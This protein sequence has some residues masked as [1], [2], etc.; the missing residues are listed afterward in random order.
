MRFGLTL[1]V[2][3]F[4]ILCYITLHHI[5]LHAPAGQ[6]VDDEGGCETTEGNDAP[7]QQDGR[8][9]WVFLWGLR[10]ETHNDNLCYSKFKDL[11]N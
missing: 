7:H 2:S 8:P 11:G 3:P 9:G 10:Q 4:Q 1:G 5:T 6:E